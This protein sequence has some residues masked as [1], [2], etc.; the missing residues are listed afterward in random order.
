M[1]PQEQSQS[2]CRRVA[3]IQLPHRPLPKLAPSVDRWPYSEFNPKSAQPFL[4]RLAEYYACPQY[5]A[6][7]PP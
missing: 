4:A 7:S 1:V 6:A 5:S 3:R 2:G